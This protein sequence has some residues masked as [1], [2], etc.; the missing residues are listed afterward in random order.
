LNEEKLLPVLRT[1]GFETID[2][3]KHTVS[4]QIAMIASA[5]VI[6]G[7]HGADLTNMIWAPRD[8]SVVEFFNRG[9]RPAFTRQMAYN[10]SLNYYYWAQKPMERHSFNHLNWDIEVDVD[11]VDRFLTK[12]FA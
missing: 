7:A 2:M 4:D 5:S 6:L 3:G 10:L 9:F 11:V 8:A 1:H 12:T